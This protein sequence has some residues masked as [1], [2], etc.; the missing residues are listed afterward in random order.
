MKLLKGKKS[1]EKFVD[2]LLDTITTSELENF[3]E[4][5]VSRVEEYNS[6]VEEYNSNVEIKIN[7]I[8]RNEY[9]NDCK[10]FDKINLSKNTVDPDIQN[11][12]A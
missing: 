10:D 1:F 4:D 3:V 12:A 7:S 8:V 5:Y 9:L 2:N 11:F 6:R